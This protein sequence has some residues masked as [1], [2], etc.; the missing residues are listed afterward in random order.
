RHAHARPRRRHR[1]RG[2][3]ASGQGDGEGH[4]ARPARAL[5][6]AV[7]APFHRTRGHPP[8]RG[9]PPTRI[10]PTGPSM[11]MNK[12]TPPLLIVACLALA[13][14]T[15]CDRSDAAAGAASAPAVKA[16][17]GYATGKA[18]NTRGE[19]IAGAKILLDNAVFY[20]SYIDT[21]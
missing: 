6:P 12:T 8:P 19:P 15:A 9:C 21:T 14:L 11:A 20:A 5:T 16:E 13:G 4:A 10:E 1:P 7:G 18:V 2:R 3:E 17:R